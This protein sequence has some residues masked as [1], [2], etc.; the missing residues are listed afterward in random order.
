MDVR[1][2]APLR[3]ADVIHVRPEILAHDALPE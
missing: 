2:D 3:L 1:R